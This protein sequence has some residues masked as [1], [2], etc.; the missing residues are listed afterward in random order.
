MI[1]M[2]SPRPPSPRTRRLR[3]RALVGALAVAF[4]VSSVVAGRPLTVSL[5]T[6]APERAATSL[7]EQISF[8]IGSFNVLG[9][10]HTRPGRGA[11]NYAPGPLR[12]HWAAEAVRLYRPGVVGL[13]EIEYDQ[14][15]VLAAELPDYSFYP[16]KSLGDSGVR[17]N[18]MWANSRF[19]KTGQG[20]IVL[21]FLGLRRS[22]HYV[23]LKD[24]ASGREFWVMNVHNSPNRGGSQTNEDER[25][26][27][28]RT[29]VAK[30]RE[31][32]RDV[33]AAGRPLPVFLVGDMN[34]KAWTYCYVVDN[35][36][37][38]A[39]QGRR[40]PGSCTLPPNSHIEW[41]FGS[42]STFTNYKYD[43]GPLLQRISDHHITFATA[44]L[45]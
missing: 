13:Q 40:T 6:P 39:S 41:I 37:L 3:I 4:V 10:W 38:E 16:G 7:T 8:R 18:I 33:D 28:V 11:A 34:D 25:R 27:Q 15:S 9:S 43:R 21:P 24:R 42:R 44:K 26:S 36:D 30:L 17:N 32:G 45:N 29:E 19:A 12:S 23:K 1:R 20:Y 22:I 31:L 2:S 5:A 14:I 35:T